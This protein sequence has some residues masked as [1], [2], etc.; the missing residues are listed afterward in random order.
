MHGSRAACLAVGDGGA[1][2]GGGGGGGG[3]DGVRGAGRVML[4]RCWA[5]VAAAP[6]VLLS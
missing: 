2:A 5:C 1:A 6:T 4:A 3:C